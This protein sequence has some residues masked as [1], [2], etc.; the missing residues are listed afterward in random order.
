MGRDSWEL[1]AESG[2]DVFLSRSSADKAGVEVLARRLE[3]E[4]R[5]R[6]FLDKWHLVPGEPWQDTLEELTGTREMD[7]TAILDYFG[8]L[9]G[10]LEQQNQGRSCGW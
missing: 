4:S 10:Y 2:Y 5:L 6:V 3:D 9:M 8:P 7:A 1:R